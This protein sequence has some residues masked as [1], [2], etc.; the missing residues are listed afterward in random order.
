M[1]PA[2]LFLPPSF[3][4][5]LLLS[6][7]ALLRVTYARCRIDSRLTPRKP[8]GHLQV[9]F[10]MNLRCP[11]EH[12]LRQGPNPST[13][14]KCDGGCK[15]SFTKKTVIFS[16]RERNTCDYY[17]CE[18][19]ATL[20]AAPPS[21]ESTSVNENHTQDEREAFHRGAE[22][23][24]KKLLCVSPGKTQL[25]QLWPRIKKEPWDAQTAIQLRLDAP[26]I[27]IDVY[28]TAQGQLLKLGMP[29][30]DDPLSLF[31]AT[32]RAAFGSEEY[33]HRLRDLTC[34]YI[35]LHSFERN[36]WRLRALELG[37]IPSPVYIVH[38]IVKVL[39]ISVRVICSQRRVDQAADA[40]VFALESEVP[41]ELGPAKG[42]V[43]IAATVG[44]TKP[45]TCEGSRSEST[46]KNE[47]SRASPSRV[48][49]GRSRKFDCV[50]YSTIEPND[51]VVPTQVQTDQ[52]S[53]HYSESLH[54]SGFGE[55][56][57]ITIGGE[58]YSRAA[59]ECGVSEGDNR[60]KL[61]LCKNQLN[62]KWEVVREHLCNFG[63]QVTPL[64]V[65]G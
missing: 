44:A 26:A 54:S 4:P 25:D 39:R 15:T 3:P 56:T 38:D 13:H 36:P 62:G 24:R 42:T 23:L 10:E 51:E 31:R 52:D 46:T 55:A 6:L 19:C 5:S 18:S 29:R 1:Q 40:N 2:Q 27:E 59:L 64:L 30:D 61:W 37:L 43:Y 16:C 28:L 50:Q 9:R 34:Q 63:R 41:A 58:E 35:R 32:S 8:S 57:I 33:A 11:N 65:R 7:L 45:I 20:E 49:A 14:L 22:E 47:L 53:N 60:H 21:H 12:P 17:L 48:R